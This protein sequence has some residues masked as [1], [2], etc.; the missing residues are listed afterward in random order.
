MGF[1]FV[2]ANTYIAHLSRAK[3]MLNQSAVV[4]LAGFN[5]EQERGNRVRNPGAAVDA[6]RK[7]DKAVERRS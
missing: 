6:G 5:E 3:K 7:G 1:V 2:A 4:E